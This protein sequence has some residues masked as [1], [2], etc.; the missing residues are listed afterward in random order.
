MSNVP[1]YT[2]FEAQEAREALGVAL[3]GDIGLAVA[4]FMQE[5][6]RQTLNIHDDLDASRF[7][8]ILVDLL[9]GDDAVVFYP[10][11]DPVTEALEAASKRV[12][13]RED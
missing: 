7:V 8:R 6:D 5:F 4:S 10:T 3:E 11:P 12:R 13:L 2:L 9:V 1:V